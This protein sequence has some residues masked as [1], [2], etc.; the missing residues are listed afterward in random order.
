MK[1]EIK[2]DYKKENEKRTDKNI[3]YRVIEKEEFIKVSKTTKARLTIT[4]HPY[5]KDEYNR[6]YENMS[7]EFE[8]FV[9]MKI[10]EKIQL[11]KAK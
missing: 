7:G 5:L 9:K 11:S 4:I 2:R 3:K 10:E 1:N 8:D 6:L